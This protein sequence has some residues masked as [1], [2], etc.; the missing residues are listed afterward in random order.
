MRQR[1]RRAAQSARERDEPPITQDMPMLPFPVDLSKR[2]RRREPDIDLPQALR[3][4]LRLGELL[5]RCGA[6]SSDVE[7]SIILS[8]RALGLP[9]I[10]IGVTYTEIQISVSGPPGRPPITDMRVVRRLSIDHTRLVAAHQL[11]LDLVDGRIDAPDVYRRFD[12]IRHAPKR[13]PRWLV[14]IGWAVLA[15]AVVVQL[16]GG[17]L[18]TVVTF[19]A[20]VL[21]DRLG[22]RLARRALPVFF[23]NAIGGAVSTAVALGLSRLGADVSYS[24]VVAG[25]VFLLLPGLSLLAA[26][27]DALTGYSVTSA[28]RGV[29]VLVLS[30]GIVSGIAF[31]LV[32]SHRFGLDMNVG[33]PVQ[34]KLIDFPVRVIAAGFVAAGLAIG[35][36]SPARLIPVSAT[37]GALGYAALLGLDHALHAPTVSR[38]LAAAAIGLVS[39]LYARRE[40]APALTLVVPGLVPLLPGLT[41]Y[42]AMIQLTQHGGIAGLPTLL[43]A[44]TEALAIAAGVILGEFLGQPVQAGLSRRERRYAGPTLVGPFRMPRRRS[45]RR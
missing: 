30:T 37:I 43:V 9:R 23:L 29:E 16:G 2:P 15:A 17:A 24:L 7:T 5:L 14:T 33:V 35:Y 44:V 34:L 36:Y 20:T 1:L 40:R 41:V 27:Q 12:E 42:S 25:G 32:I 19:A 39:Q 18:V 6:G 11:V 4:L 31:V 21:I 22:R 45:R 10:E 8:A 38:G 3:F 13:Y 28:A 26:V